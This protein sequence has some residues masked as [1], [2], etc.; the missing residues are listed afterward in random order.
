[1]QRIIKKTN[2]GSTTI[3]LPDLDENYHS[4]HGAIQEALHVFIQHGLHTFPTNK[5]LNIFEMGFGTGL[6]AGL[7]L[8]EA[9]QTINY[10]GIEA[11]PVEE[12]LL[13]ELNYSELHPKL[14]A[15]I[16]S[17]IHS[18]EW[19]QLCPITENFNLK[20]IK[21][22]IEDFQLP[23][24]YFDL[25]YFDAFGSRAQKEMWN[26]DILEKMFLG[27]KPEGKLVTYCAKGQFKRD[28]KSLGF[29]VESL[30]GPPGKREMTR[31]VKP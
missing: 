9:Q 7:T 2:D 20:K 23:S 6:N 8:S 28:L 25:I 30:P 18:V 21:S 11:Y 31:A 22:K 10:F 24:N 3:Y 13:K 5:P 15:S 1:M 12:T 29:M 27:L 14:T 26:I 4:N 17:K 19:N 16:F